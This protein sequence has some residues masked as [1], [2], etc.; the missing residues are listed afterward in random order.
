MCKVILESYIWKVSGGMLPQQTF[1]KKIASYLCFLE[2]KFWF[3]WQIDK[4]MEKDLLISQIPCFNLAVCTN[5]RE[6]MA[7][8]WIEIAVTEASLDT[9]LPC[10]LG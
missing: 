5:P 4:H 10:F 3:T 8:E 6:E 1:C 7:T 9:A 2:A